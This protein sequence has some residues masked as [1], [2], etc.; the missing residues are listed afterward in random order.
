[1][2]HAGSLAPKAATKRQDASTTR[3]R[4][5]SARHPRRVCQTAGG[6]DP[7][8]A[9]PY[10][11]PSIGRPNHQSDLPA[12]HT[13][14]GCPRR[15]RDRHCLE[16]L[17]SDCLSGLLGCGVPRLRAALPTHVAAETTAIRGSP[18]GYEKSRGLGRCGLRVASMSWRSAEP[19]FERRSA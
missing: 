18:S 17:T 9:R 7:C 10:R 19:G 2:D 11:S 13:R 5:Y 6:D 8:D 1:M 16:H 15:R 12:G 3:L 14:G 4:P